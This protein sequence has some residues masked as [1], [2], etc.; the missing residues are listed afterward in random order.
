MNEEQIALNNLYNAS[1]L[2]PLPADHHEQLRKCAELLQSK[3]LPPP[4]EEPKP[5]E[6]KPKAKKPVEQK[7][8]SVGAAK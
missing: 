1:R 4:A 3:I 7:P 2:A 6:Q 8:K 5:V